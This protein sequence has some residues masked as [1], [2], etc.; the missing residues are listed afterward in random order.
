MVLVFSSCSV[1]AGC[2]VAGAGAF[3]VA[4]ADAL[5]KHKPK[6][7]GRAQLGVQAFADALLV[8]PKVLEKPWNKNN[9]FK[10]VCTIIVQNIN[11]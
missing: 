11:I 9:L 4:L 7:K 6:V 1:F 8:I 10:N 2:V 5:V 3:E